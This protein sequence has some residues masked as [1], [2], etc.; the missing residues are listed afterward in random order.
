MGRE[1]AMTGDFAR[2]RSRFDIDARARAARVALERDA[3]AL[4][5]YRPVGTPSSIASWLGRITRPVRRVE[6]GE[7]AEPAAA[8]VC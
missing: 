8:P 6:V 3:L 1:A 5:A 4:G 7:P 2:D